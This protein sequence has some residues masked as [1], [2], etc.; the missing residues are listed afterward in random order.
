MNPD[1]PVVVEI[2]GDGK[3]DVGAPAERVPPS[4]GVVPIL[5]HTLS[6]RP[7]QMMVTTRF[8][9]ELIG[10]TFRQKVH[11]FKRQAKYN[12]SH[13]AV[14]VVDSEVSHRE[15]K[16]LRKDLE[17]GRDAAFPELPMAV[18]IAHPCIE[19]WLLADPA[20]IR[21]A[22]NLEELPTIP[23]A[24]EDLPPPHKDR[25]NN[26][27]AV[28]GNLAGAIGADEKWDIAKAMNDIEFVKTR[29]PL[30]FRPFAAEVEE[31]IRPLFDAAGAPG[32]SDV[33]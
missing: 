8:R 26:P 28:L 17:E 21:K 25:K 20:A 7:A 13:A 14:M 2:C 33:E 5:V 29:C 10:K 6:G 24:P 16:R 30:G 23:E 22:M 3:T 9:M 19:A 18:G 27:K 1:T 31:R 15:L 12:G 11:F 32:H 4:E